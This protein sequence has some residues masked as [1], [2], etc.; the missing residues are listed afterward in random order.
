MRARAKEGQVKLSKAQ[1]AVAKHH[2]NKTS[3]EE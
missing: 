2:N 1:E 3:K